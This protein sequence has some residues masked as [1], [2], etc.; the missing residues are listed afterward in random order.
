MRE[1]FLK[2]QCISD[3]KDMKSRENRSHMCRF[4]IANGVFMVKCRTDENSKPPPVQKIFGEKIIVLRSQL[5][6]INAH[7][8]EYSAK[9]IIV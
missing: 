1:S 5:L 6:K 7:L 4:V 2:C 3:M 9:R 8:R